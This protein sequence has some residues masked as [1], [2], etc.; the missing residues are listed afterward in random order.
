MNEPAWVD[1]RTALA[2]HRRQLAEHGGADGVRDAGLLSSAL[3]RPMNRRAYEESA[4]LADRAELAA[5]YAHGIITNHPFVDGNKR[6]GYVVAVLFLRLNG[7]VLRA[8]SD[9]KYLTIYGLAAGTISEPDLANWIRTH[10]VQT[11][12]P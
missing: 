9:D 4:D 8:S 6:T 1:E 11:D 12:H 3:A 2:V 7:L 5:A 10:C